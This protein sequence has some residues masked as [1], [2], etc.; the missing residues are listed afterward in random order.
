M[1][2]VKEGQAVGIN[3]YMQYEAPEMPVTGRLRILLAIDCCETVDHCCAHSAW[4]S[5]RGQWSVVYLPYCGLLTG[6]VQLAGDLG[7][8]ARR[9]IG[10]WDSVSPHRHITSS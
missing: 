5:G 6:D 4:P 9:P 7:A 10:W 1:V 8:Y 2:I 3:L